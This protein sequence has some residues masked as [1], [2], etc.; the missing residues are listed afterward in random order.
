MALKARYT[1][2]NGRLI[3]EKRNGVRSFYMADGIGSTRALLDNTQTKTD[4]FTYWPYGEEKSRTGTTPTPFRYG[5]ALG[6]YRDAGGR[7][8]IRHRSYQAAYGR[9]MTKDPLFT[10]SDP[11][12]YGSSNPATFVD[13]SGLAPQYPRWPSPCP[14][15]GPIE[16][17]YATNERIYMFCNCC[18][19]NLLGDLTCQWE[20][21]AAANAYYRK[22]K[23]TPGPGAFRPPPGGG[24]VA[25]RRNPRAAGMDEACFAPPLPCKGNPGD[26]AGCVDFGW[27]K[28]LPPKM[29]PIVTPITPGGGNVMDY[30]L[31]AA[32]CD[33]LFGGTFDSTCNQWLSDCKATCW[34]NAVGNLLRMGYNAAKAVRSKAND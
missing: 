29:Q 18:H 23:G 9:W 22:C 24:E 3:A 16:C 20:C 1:N 28:E 14:S 6:M 12:R 25:P 17:D 27:G 5:G 4:T 10:Y 31:C 26:I 13:T 30:N 21:S 34:G 19:S 11:Y 32:C 8:F 15:I 2:A 7:L 33:S